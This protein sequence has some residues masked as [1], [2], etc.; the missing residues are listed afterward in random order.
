M[1]IRDSN[2]VINNINNILCININNIKNFKNI[3]NKINNLKKYNID[4][5]NNNNNN[6]NNFNNIITN[7]IKTQSEMAF[8][9]FHN[10]Y[11]QFHLRPSPR[12]VRL[13]HSLF[14]NK[15]LLI[16]DL[17]HNLLKSII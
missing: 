16:N 2:N 13:Q 1:C 4:N 6:N 12:I 10:H 15:I 9:C 7:N 11:F 8:N 3:K 17:I 5:N 14:I